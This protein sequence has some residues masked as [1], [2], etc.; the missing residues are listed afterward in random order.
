MTIFYYN[1]DE[2]TLY[3]FL[4]QN[5]S[6]INDITLQAIRKCLDSDL[7]HLDFMKIKPDGQVYTIKR[8]SFKKFLQSALS[9]YE[10]VEMYEKCSECVELLK[11]ID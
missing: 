9:Y 4:N 7:Q 3:E 10:S 8:T 2:I 1:S 6:K 11:E 5:Q